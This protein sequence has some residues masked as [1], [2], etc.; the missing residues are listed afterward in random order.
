MLIQPF[1]ENA[2]RH[3]LL[4]KTEGEGQLLLEFSRQQ[5][6][7]R[8]KISDNGIGRKKLQAQKSAAMQDHVSRGMQIVKERLQ[9]QAVIEKSPIQID[10]KDMYQ[11]ANQ[12]PGTIVMI[13]MPYRQK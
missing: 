10:I 12:D 7:L 13:T 2:I 6:E 3:G 11:E 5:E 4:N 9:L 8:C 1:V